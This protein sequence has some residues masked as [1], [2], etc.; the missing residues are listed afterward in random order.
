M[1]DFQEICRETLIAVVDNHQQYSS[2][3]NLNIR[4]QHRF[5]TQS[6]VI[7]QIW[8]QAGDQRGFRNKSILA[9]AIHELV[10]RGWLI[11][12]RGK[13]NAW[14]YFPTTNGIK[15]YNEINQSDRK[16]VDSPLSR[17]NQTLALYQKRKGHLR[18][19]DVVTTLKDQF[20]HLL[21]L[22]QVLREIS[23]R[24]LASADFSHSVQTSLS[25]IGTI[26]GADLI[27]LS[28]FQE[29][30]STPDQLYEGVGLEWR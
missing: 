18:I 17:M 30:K 25:D 27:S 2:T 16:N 7:Q 10:R 28:L 12:Q 22:E 21:E 11:R 13:Q 24:F 23:A 29:D 6:A 20:D 9:K 26:L 8:V 1:V 15:K 14:L 4:N 19:G 5:L 3:R